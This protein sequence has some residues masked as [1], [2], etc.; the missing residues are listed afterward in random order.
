[1]AR[2]D[3]LDDV[4]RRILRAV[5]DLKAAELRSRG[6]IVG[7]PE[8][9]ATAAEVRDLARAVFKLSE[10]QVVIGQ[11]RDSGPRA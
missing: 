7:S 9:A 2:L 6:M 3:E 8:F 11:Q 1:M 10:E 5:E 4:S